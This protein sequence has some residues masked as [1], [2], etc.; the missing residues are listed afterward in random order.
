MEPSCHHEF[1]RKFLLDHF[2]LSYL[3]RQYTQHFNALAVQR[4]IP[5]LPQTQELIRLKDRHHKRQATI[6]TQLQQSPDNVSLN[7]LYQFYIGIAK[8]NLYADETTEPQQ[9]ITSQEELDHHV[10][11][12]DPE[13]YL[14]SSGHSSSSKEYAHQYHGKCPSNDCKGLLTPEY[15]CGICHV[16]VCPDCHVALP[17]PSEATFCNPSVDEDGTPIH[18]CDTSLVESI[19]TIAQETKPCPTCHVPIYKTEGCSHMWCVQ[20]HTAFS[21]K[22]GQPV[23]NFHN[24]HHQEW[25]ASTTSTYPS[26]LPPHSIPFGRGMFLQIRDQLIKHLEKKQCHPILSFYLTLCNGVMFMET[27]IQPAIILNRFEIDTERLREN[28]LRGTLQ[29][30]EYHTRMGKAYRDLEYHTETNAI[31]KIYYI[32]QMKEIFGCLLEKLTELSAITDPDPDPET[33]LSIVSKYTKQMERALHS[34]ESLLEQCSKTHWKAGFFKFIYKKET[35]QIGG[36]LSVEIDRITLG[37]SNNT[38]TPTPTPSG[39]QVNYLTQKFTTLFETD[40]TP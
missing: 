10:M 30:T 18:Q 7:Y 32:D 11:F 24:P 29:E 36:N 17:P 6:K 3:Q 31:I 4:E 16:Q 20:C 13:E 23:K 27:I 25:L 35:R 21:W 5:K 12:Y 26:T 1:S 9:P 33:C 14:Q 37:I 19:Q 8:N 22:T 15:Q 34:T 40:F 28:Y 38:P 2:K 39:P